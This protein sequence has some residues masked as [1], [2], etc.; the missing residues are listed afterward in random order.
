MKCN[1]GNM[2]DDYLTT[3][4]VSEILGCSNV[5]VTRLVK[6]GYFPGTRKFNP[7]RKNSGLRIPREAVDAFVKAQVVTP[8]DQPEQA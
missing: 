6:Q 5:H 4:E 8:E 3:K 1:I 2:A 7:A